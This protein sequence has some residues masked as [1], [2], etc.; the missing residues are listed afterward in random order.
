MSQEKL[1]SRE[2]RQKQII[3]FLS[4]NDKPVSGTALAKE[5]GV[6]RQ[7]I[8]QDIALLRSAK[9]DIVSTNRGYIVEHKS[10]DRVTRILKCCHSDEDA[11]KELNC[12]VDQ[13]GSVEKVFVNSKLYGHLEAPMEIHSRRDVKAFLEKKKSGKSTLL[14]NVTSDYHYH[15]I[16]AES[17]EILDDI[18]KELEEQG[19]LVAP[20]EQ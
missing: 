11:E 13:G 4:E 12:I 20:K 3:Q 7:V 5:F 10:V 2:E 1:L 19:F 9:L 16:S 18:E 8:V 17:E 6:S 15:Q 14:K